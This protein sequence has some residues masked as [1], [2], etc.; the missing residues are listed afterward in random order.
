MRVLPDVG[1]KSCPGVRG[2]VAGID[3]R[4]TAGD[5]PDIFLNGRF[6]S[7]EERLARRLEQ[8]THK[9]GQRAEILEQMCSRTDR[10]APA[11]P[12][13][14]TK[15]GRYAEIRERVDCRPAHSLE[16]CRRPLGGRTSSLFARGGTPQSGAAFFQSADSSLRVGGRSFSGWIDD[17]PGRGRSL[18]DWA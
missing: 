17:S 11:E 16:T 4:N 1:E 6:T 5:S 12:P 2:R 9:R 15:V 18:L 7:E 8:L 10:L 13:V 14:V 3:G